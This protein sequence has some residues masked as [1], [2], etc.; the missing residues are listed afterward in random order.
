MGFETLILAREESFAVITLTGRPP[1]PS[2]SA[3]ARAET[4]RWTGV[5]TD[6]AVRS[7]IITGRRR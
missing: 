4:R 1:T 7:V 2:A 5:Q 3:D 6:E